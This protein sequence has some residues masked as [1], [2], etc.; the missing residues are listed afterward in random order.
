[1][2][3]FQGA[4]ESLKS[5]WGRLGAVSRYVVLAFLVAAL[6]LL[7][8]LGSAGAVKAMVRLPAE[9]DRAQ[10]VS[11][12]RETGRRFE[13]RADGVYVSKTELEEASLDLAAEGLLDAGKAIDFK[14]SIF[15]TQWDREKRHQAALQ[16]RLEG[17]IRKVGPVHNARVLLTPGSEARRLGETAAK[18]S[19]SVMLTLKP[20]RE[21]SDANVSAIARFVAGAVKG[22]GPDQV[23]ITD[24][25]LR[26]YGMPRSDGTF[27]TANSRHELEV[28]YEK[29]FRADLERFFPRSIPVVRVK[30][31]SESSQTTSERHGQA[32]P[33]RERERRE[34]QK[35]VQSVPG[36]GIKGVEGAP[37]A[38]P[39]PAGA[40]VTD[41]E[42]Q[43]AIDR[44]IRK[45]ENPAGEIE[46]ITVALKIPVD[47]ADVNNPREVAAAETR[48]GE[49][50]K[51]V[52]SSV[53]APATLE[54]V[55]VSF[56]P[57]RRPEPLP[58]PA[59]APES[60]GAGWTSYV[61]WIVLG[62]VVVGMLVGLLA[63]M[64][65]ALSPAPAG[66]P[67]GIAPGMTVGEQELGRI[68]QGIREM[69]DQNPRGAAGVVRRWMAGR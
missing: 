51:Q 31:K 17:I 6:V 52:L 21:L 10:V 67:A 42:V 65:R 63:M 55:T 61:Q 45:S 15:D 11:R 39:V 4:W 57:V 3:V 30:C 24:D 53:G 49:I 28:S 59:A 18:A 41:L 50:Q 16:Q 37:A 35:G 23:L 60:A 66:V 22:L 69:V 56:F 8:V 14:D 29:K 44:E 20:G 7:F 36:S 33:I 27:G 13:L 40:T 43:N 2:D 62:V 9:G 58:P 1:M 12:L 25:Q 34:V 32:R 26:S 5:A 46:K 47:V 64:W 38:E 68:R 48:R 19:A 54:D